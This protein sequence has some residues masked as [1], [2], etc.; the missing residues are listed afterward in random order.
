MGLW[1]NHSILSFEMKDRLYD[2]WAR[3]HTLGGGGPKQLVTSC[4]VTYWEGTKRV[5]CGAKRQKVA[6]RLAFRV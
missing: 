4:R 2:V 6:K 1:Q 5:W 3:T